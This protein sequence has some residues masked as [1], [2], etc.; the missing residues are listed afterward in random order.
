ML[1]NLRPWSDHEFDQKTK[2]LSNFLQNFNTKIR[3]IQLPRVA[4]TFPR[5]VRPSRLAWVRHVAAISPDAFWRL[6]TAVAF[7]AEKMGFVDVDVAEIRVFAWSGFGSACWS[8]NGGFRCVRPWRRRKRKWRRRRIRRRKMCGLDVN[9]RRCPCSARR[10]LFAVEGGV[11]C[12]G[13]SRLCL[14]CSASLF[15]C[16]KMT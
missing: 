3:F 14:I 8:Q 5:Y 2:F 11:S 6:H 10:R 15:Y 16:F 4:R 1:A 12:L 9:W 13:N 7:A